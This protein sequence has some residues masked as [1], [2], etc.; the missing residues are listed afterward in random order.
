MHPVTF[1]LSNK[2]TWMSRR[3]R[4]KNN[5]V[6]VTDWAAAMRSVYNLLVDVS[7]KAELLPKCS[8]LR[9]H[10][11]KEKRCWTTNWSKHPFIKDPAP[12]TNIGL[13]STKKQ[14]RRVVK[15]KRTLPDQAKPI[16]QKVTL[17]EKD[18]D[19]NSSTR[20]M[21]IDDDRFSKSLPLP[22]QTTT[23]NT[24]NSILPRNLSSDDNKNYAE[25]LAKPKMITPAGSP[26]R[27]NEH[28]DSKLLVPGKHI[29]YGA[30]PQD[31]KHRV[32]AFNKV[33]G[34]EEYVIVQMHLSENKMTVRRLR[35][36]ATYKI[37]IRC[38]SI[39]IMLET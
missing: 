17:T 15:R 9:N 28:A 36:N 12:E 26:Q 4:S 33:P 6:D 16:P 10:H 29:W 39:R 2:L 22:S 31:T 3:L 35:T 24:E 30:D 1:H 11:T 37:K 38:D 32:W 13:L 5:A 18:R 7:G 19:E 20:D 25:E 21:N 27:I 14:M 23:C 8:P 34:S